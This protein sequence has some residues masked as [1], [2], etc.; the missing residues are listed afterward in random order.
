LALAAAIDGLSER[1][2]PMDAAGRPGGDHRLMV[3]GGRLVRP[4]SLSLSLSL[5]A[6]SIQIAPLAAVGVPLVYG[7]TV[8]ARWSHGSLASWPWSAAP[9]FSPFGLITEWMMSCP[10]DIRACRNAGA[11]I[12][13]GRELSRSG[14]VRFI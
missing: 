7:T 8:L 3:L 1:P 4:L 14:E 5:G 9:L 10:R 11:H 6:M 13:I 2:A 12:L